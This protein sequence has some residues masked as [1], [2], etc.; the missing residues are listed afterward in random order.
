MSKSIETMGFLAT[1][2]RFNSMSWALSSWLTHFSRIWD[3]APAR[4]NLRWLVIDWGAPFQQQQLRPLARK[5]QLYQPL[6]MWASVMVAVFK[7]LSPADCSCN[8]T[9]KCSPQNVQRKRR[10]SGI[11]I[12]PRHLRPKCWGCLLAQSHH[13]PELQGACFHHEILH[14]LNDGMPHS[15]YLPL[16]SQ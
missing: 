4:G 1:V 12:W 6:L 10:L 3:C 15:A 9:T 11:R 14:D 16:H 7:R 13:H 8:L 2:S 5:S